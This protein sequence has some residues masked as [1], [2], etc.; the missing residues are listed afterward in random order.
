MPRGYL[1]NRELPRTS[2]RP[3]APPGPLTHCVFNILP[4]RIMRAA[5]IAA[6][7]AAGG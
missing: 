1:G 7:V 4:G 3:T 5:A 6:D 2:G